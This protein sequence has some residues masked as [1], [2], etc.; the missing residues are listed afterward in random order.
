[1]ATRSATCVMTPPGS[2]QCDKEGVTVGGSVNQPPS[3]A[4]DAFVTDAGGV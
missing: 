3:A 2:R 1:M 4:G